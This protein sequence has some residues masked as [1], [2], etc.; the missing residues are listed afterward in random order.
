MI[1]ALVFDGDGMVIIDEK[2]SHRLEKEYGIA[3]GKTDHFFHREYEECR[4]GKA[5]LKQ[6][7]V[8][9]LGK[10]GWKGSLEEFL[11]FWFKGNRFDERFSSVIKMLQSKGVKCVLATNQE[12]YR[13]SFIKKEMG[14][15]KVFDH[16][17]LSSDLHCKKPE[18]EYFDKMLSRL[19]LEKHEV[20]LWD[21]RMNYVQK[22]R[23][24]GL[25]AAL[26][27]DFHSFH[28]EME[29]LFEL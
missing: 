15:E 17:F 10:W 12:K 6:E 22:A 14:L 4:V 1:K 20:M 18:P 27:S 13:G 19:T 5:D 25:N 8:K 16:I 2:F 28:K 9:Y 21:D 23:E 24:Y 11:G 7:L 29:R 26:Y 3:L